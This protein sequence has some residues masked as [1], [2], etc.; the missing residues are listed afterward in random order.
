VQVGQP[1]AF[2]LACLE[3]NQIVGGTRCKRAHLVEFGVI[4]FRDHTALAQD[5]GR[6]IDQCLRQ[7]PGDRREFAHA[8][9]KFTRQR[10]L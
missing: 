1:A 7:A 5:H 10:C 8:R 4:A 2:A 9:Q 6:V 3:A